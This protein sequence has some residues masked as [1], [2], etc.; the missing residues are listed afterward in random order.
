MSDAI[1][2]PDVRAKHAAWLRGKP[3]G[4]RANLAGADLREA[5]LRWADLRWAGLAGADLREADL[6]ALG[7]DA[8][9]Y[10]FYAYAN[11]DGVVEIR[12]GCRQFTGIAAARAHW[13]AAHT[14]DL[15]LR[16]DCL[17]LVQRAET[18][19]VARG[20]KLETDTQE[21]QP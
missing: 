21:G 12:A 5:D 17:S 9:G 4:Q 10:L 15:V 20:W 1:N 7:H 8:R 3:D 14:D 19:A 11:D 18:M 2:L 6:V 13:Q 16:A